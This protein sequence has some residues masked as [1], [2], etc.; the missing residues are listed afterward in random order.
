MPE[1]SLTQTAMSKLAL[2]GVPIQSG[3]LISVIVVSVLGKGAFDAQQK[4]TD[5]L[6]DAVI[7]VRSEVTAMRSEQAEYEKAVQQVIKLTAE[8]ETLKREQSEL[9]ARLALAIECA[10]SK[11][12]CRL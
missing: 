7:D 12:R 8:I 6:A 4:A 11:Q 10:K 5:D 3:T 2:A 1:A 9:E